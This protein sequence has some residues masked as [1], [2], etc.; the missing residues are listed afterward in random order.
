MPDRVADL[1]S[2]NLHR[3]HRCDESTG[4]GGEFFVRGGQRV[5]LELSYRNELSLVGIRPVQLSGDAP[6]LIL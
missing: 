2:E 1:R 4:C 5:R 3:G 6:S